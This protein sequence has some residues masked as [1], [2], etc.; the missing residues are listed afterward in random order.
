MC[1]V[2]NIGDTWKEQFPKQ[3]PW[4]PSPYLP[5]IAP[6]QLAPPGGYP[7]AKIID[8][9]PPTREEFDRLKKDVEALKELL[10]AAK[11]YDEKTNQKDCEMDEK[12]EFIKKVADAVGVNLEDVFGKTKT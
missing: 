7:P 11:I 8:I 4:Y 1:T 5:G 6:G 12:I 3:Y 9:N 2:S 10:K